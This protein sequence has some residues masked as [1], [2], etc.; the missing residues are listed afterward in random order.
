MSKAK[1]ILKEIGVAL[2]F[3]EEEQKDLDKVLDM[4]EDKEETTETTEQKFVEAQ[5][6]DGTLVQIE[7][8]VAVGAV[9]AV[10]D[11]ENGFVAVPAGSYELADGRIV[12]VE[13]GGVI[14]EVQEVAAE[15]EA[16]DTESDEAPK[17]NEA[18]IKKVIESVTTVFEAQFEALKKEN[19]ELKKEM[20]ELQIEFSKV[21]EEGSEM[22][23]KFYQALTELADQPAQEA[24]ENKKKN[25]PIL[26]K[27]RSNGIDNLKRYFK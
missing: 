4:T 7:P 8:D 11:P 10:E 24:T 15:E 26:D 19:E 18:E 12:V 22:N 21:K 9:M 27:S 13:E 1:E 23:G 17:M 2:G 3:N 5:L 20:D 14:A 6:A 25:N 16:M